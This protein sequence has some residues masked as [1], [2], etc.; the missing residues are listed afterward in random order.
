M[1]ASSPGDEV[2]VTNGWYSA[3]GRAVLGLMT[4][5]VAVDRPVLLR[6]VNGAEATVIEGYRT[7]GDAV[8]AIGVST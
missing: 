5:R 1:D 2:V 6:S 8:G 7:S 3:G 4:N